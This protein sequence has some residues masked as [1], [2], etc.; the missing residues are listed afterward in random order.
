MTYGH[1]IRKSRVNAVTV[2]GQLVF[3]LRDNWNSPVWLTLAGFHAI[4]F[5]C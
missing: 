1:L 2:Y 5:F 3:P 4:A